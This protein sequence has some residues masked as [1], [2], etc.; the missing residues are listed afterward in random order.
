[1]TPL[2]HLVPLALVLALFGAACA[3]A[4]GD[5]G[6]ASGDAA[7]TSAANATDVEVLPFEDIQ[8][9]DV[10]FEADP[11]D[12][13]R[14]I[15][16]VTTTIET[17]CAIVWGETEDLGRFNNSLAMS[18]TGIIQHDVVLPDLEQG[19]EYFFIMQGTD[20]DGNLYRSEL[21]TFTIPVTEAAEAEPEPDLG[22]NIAE[23]AEIADVSSEFGDAFVASNAVD[24]DLSTEWSSREDGDGAFITVDLGEETEITGVAFLTRSMADGSAITEEYTVTTDGGEVLGPFPAGNPAQARISEVTATATTLTFEVTSSTGGNV[25]AVEI[26]VFAG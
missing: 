6:A 9:S 23:G 25:G 10:V 13:S 3:D 17:I 12:P 24:G 20:A 19:R 26:Q 7:D 8:D 4:S 15:F 11:N 5:S 18:G 1:M 14:G 21:D 2:R 16:R 22:P